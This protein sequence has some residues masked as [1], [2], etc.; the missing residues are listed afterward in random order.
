MKPLSPKHAEAPSASTF[1]ATVGSLAGAWN[2]YSGVLL[3]VHDGDVGALGGVWTERRRVGGSGARGRGRRHRPLLQGTS[4]LAGW[5]AWRCSGSVP[6]LEQRSPSAGGK[7]TTRRGRPSS[8][9]AVSQRVWVAG[10]QVEGAKILL[11]L[12]ARSL[13]VVECVEQSQSAVLIC[14]MQNGT[15]SPGEG[16]LPF[17]P[18]PV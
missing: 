15:V 13:E 18:S 1:F 14:V 16:W 3:G 5:Q 12:A 17:L 6:G 8:P 4:A 11:A 2:S 9:G 10:V 7:T